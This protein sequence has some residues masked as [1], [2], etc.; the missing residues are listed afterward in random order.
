MKNLKKFLALGLAAAMA[1]SVAACGNSS[2]SSSDN[3]GTQGEKKTE[4]VGDKETQGGNNEG[5]AREILIGSWWVQ[6][7]DSTHTSVEDDPSYTGDL[8]AELK[9]ENVKKI[10]E[11][12]NVTFKWVNLT[13]EGTKESIN[14]SILAGSPDCDIYLVDTG[15]AIPAQVNGLAMDMKEVLPADSDLLSDQILNKYMDLGDGKACI[16]KRVEAQSV[17]EAT[18]PLAFNKQI[19]EAANLEDPRELYKRGEW[20][21]DKF[22]E[23]LRVLTKDTD[24]DGA[25]DQYG[26]AGYPPETFEALMLSNGANIAATDKENLSSSEVGQA[27]QMTQDLFY[28]DGCAFPYENDTDKMRN[29]YRDGNIAFW[30]SACWIAANNKD[31][32]VSTPDKNLQFDTVYCR[33]PVGPSGNQETNYAKNLTSGE[34]YIIP[35]GVENPELVYNVLLSMWDWFDG[36]TTIRDSKETLSWWYGSIAKDETLQ[37]ENFD[38]MFEMGSRDVLDL[39]QSFGFN[40]D[41]DSL[42][43]GTMTPAQFQETFKQQVQDGLDAVYKK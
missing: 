16:I 25:V 13:Y 23:Y 17:V 36:D 21:W 43:A 6:Y 30:P 4:N 18:Y 33:W 40:Y 31:Y 1:V 20:T 5:K 9:F 12:Y 27:L 11:K 8:A 35:A 10:E 37:V 38:M 3:K 15:M 29:K 39:W 41:F 32:D 22:K 2:S 24:G 26:F 14:N 19:L 28:N 42:I 34:F 7:Y